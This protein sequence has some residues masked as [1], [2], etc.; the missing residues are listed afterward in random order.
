MLSHPSIIPYL[1]PARKAALAEKGLSLLVNKTLGKRLDKT[2]QVSD[3]ERR[4]LEK[5]QLHYAG[6]LS[7]FIEVF[8][9]AELRKL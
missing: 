7:F 5:Q 6:K 4:P 8:H 2:F 9:I 3:W 1:Y